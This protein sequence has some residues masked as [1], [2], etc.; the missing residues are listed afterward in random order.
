MGQD[1]IRN[2]ETHSS[3]SVTLK[4]LQKRPL[5]P[6]PPPFIRLIAVAIASLSLTPYILMAVFSSQSVTMVPMNHIRPAV[7]ESFAALK[8]LP[9]DFCQ[10]SRTHILQHLELHL[11]ICPVS[12]DLPE[13]QASAAAFPHGRPARKP[14]T[15]HACVLTI[16][17]EELHLSHIASPI[18]YIPNRFSAD[19]ALA[20]FAKHV[21]YS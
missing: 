7:V 18:Y 2:K 13:P 19:R 16:L 6:S 11:C 21:C 9:T 3:T 5:S 15:S 1:L 4:D 12:I 8:R 17:I 10:R 14:V 20:R